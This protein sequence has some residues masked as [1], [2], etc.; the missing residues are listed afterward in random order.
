[1]KR[2]LAYQRNLRVLL[3]QQGMVATTE[4]VPLPA[5]CKI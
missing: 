2:N 1:V 4:P 5:V 3:A